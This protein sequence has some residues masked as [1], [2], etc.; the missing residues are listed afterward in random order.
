MAKGDKL[1]I[2]MQ[3]QVGRPGGV[4]SND[5]FIAHIEDQSNP[6]RVTAAQAGAVDLASFE[7]HKH[8]PNAHEEAHAPILKQLADHETRIRRLEDAIYNDITGNPHSYLFDTLE[9]IRVVSGCWNKTKNR[10]E[11]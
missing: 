4:A 5:D 10:L 2:V 8:D 3:S 1:P 9:G 7:V 11:C 6:H